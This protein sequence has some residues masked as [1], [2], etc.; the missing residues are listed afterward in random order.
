MHNER[1]FTIAEAA[2]PFVCGGSSAILATTI[3]HPIDLTKVRLQLARE[4][5]K[6]PE[7]F[8]LVRET[9]KNEGIKGMYSGLSAAWVRQA[10]YGSARIGLHQS[11][12][13]FLM[14]RN[15]GE[16]I[17]FYQK[18]ISAMA[19][20]AIAVCIG[21]P[22]DVALV[23]MQ[24]DGNKPPELRRNYGNVF[25]A[26]LSIIRKEGV[27]TLWTGL[28]P[29]IL[30]GMSMNVG[31][32]ACY[33]QAKET[34]TKFTKDPDSLTTR[35]L[36]SWAGGFFCAF[37]SLP[38]DMIKSRL[39][40]MRADLKTGE[41]P[42]KGVFHCGMRVIRE[43]GFHRLWTGFGAYYFRCAPHTMIILLTRE[44]IRHKYRE[45]FGIT[46]TTM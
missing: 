12:S 8:P 35:I 9:L 16:S 42:Y 31:M 26:L 24:S 30:R 5:G 11:F 15:E 13:N 39:Q 18:N 33:D 22:F 21:T 17:P 20:G 32:M 14:K 44:N 45:V 43:E 37:L 6:K 10:T 46:E 29:N 19:G 1:K 40:N 23:R 38:F 3:I 2:Q 28:T 27:L 4:L 25:N 41:F 34:I 7:T 36:A